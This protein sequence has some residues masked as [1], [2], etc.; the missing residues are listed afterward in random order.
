[1]VMRI[2]L[3]CFNCVVEQGSGEEKRGALFYSSGSQTSIIVITTISLFPHL[4]LL[5]FFSTSQQLEKTERNCPKKASKVFRYWIKYVCVQCAYLPSFY[6]FYDLFVFYA[7][8]TRQRSPFASHPVDFIPS[9]G[10]SGAVFMCV[11]LYLF[12]FLWLQNIFLSWKKR[13][14]PYPMYECVRWWS[15]TGGVVAEK[16]SDSKI[17][18]ARNQQSIPFF[19]ACVSTTTITNCSSILPPSVYFFENTKV[20]LLSYLKILLW[21]DKVHISLFRCQNECFLKGDFFGLTDF[22][23]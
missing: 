18:H 10:M 17:P 11:H 4:S 1:M 5:I 22:W 15:K 8:R 2:P 13:G 21:M 3:L 6:T 20:T 14:T 23:N 9:I 19:H 16:R 12:S 7:E